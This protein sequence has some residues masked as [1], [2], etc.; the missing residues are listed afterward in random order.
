MACKACL[1]HLAQACH[2]RSA[3]VARI[4]QPAAQHYC[5]QWFETAELTRFAPAGASLCGL[6]EGRHAGGVRCLHAEGHSG[7]V[8][9]VCYPAPR[10]EGLLKLLLVGCCSAGL[11][12]HHGCCH[13]HCLI[14]HQCKTTHI[15]VEGRACEHHAQHALPPPAW[16]SSRVSTALGEI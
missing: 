8:Q 15:A 1:L 6:A 16:R 13:R 3:C 2:L 14:S 5:P 11:S 12:H 4:V 7:S 9:G 10:R